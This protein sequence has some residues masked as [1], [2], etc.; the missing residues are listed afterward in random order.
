MRVS[1]YPILRVIGPGKLAKPALQVAFFS[2]YSQVL[3]SG[4]RALDEIFK[5]CFR[6]LQLTSDFMNHFP[7]DV[8]FSMRV[9]NPQDF[10]II[11]E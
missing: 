7:G 4:K 9:V 2:E 10:N 5:I 8:A 3:L 11:Y 6:E 1:A